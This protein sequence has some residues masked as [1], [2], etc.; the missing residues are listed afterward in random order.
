MVNDPTNSYNFVNTAYEAGLLMNNTYTFQG[1]VGD[2]RYAHLTIGGWNEQDMSGDIE[3]YNST[4]FESLKSWKITITNMTLDKYNLLEAPA[5]D[6]P[7]QE[8]GEDA[9]DVDTEFMSYGHFNSG[10][11]FIGVDPYVADLVKDDLKYFRPDVECTYNAEK[12]PWA[13][14]Y[15]QDICDPDIFNG[16]NL[17]FSFGSNATYVLPT[18]QLMINYTM[19]SV[20]YCGVAVQKITR[21]PWDSTTE[22]H[23]YFGDIFFKSFVG[24]FDISSGRLGMAKS[25]L[26]PDTVELQCA[27][28]CVEPEPEPT[29]TPTPTPPEPTPEPLP[30][31]GDDSSD[32][33][34]MWLWIVIA[35]G[36]LLLIF[37]AIAYYYC[38]KSQKQDGV[39][40]ILYADGH[41]GGDLIE[42]DLMAQKGSQSQFSDHADIMRETD[43]GDSQAF[44]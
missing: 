4:A 35:L 40:A 29:P 24:V 14:C 6:P 16:V 25:I 36:I 21:M 39:N 10:Y 1:L 31:P 17:T 22:R 38:R 7:A 32:D 2:S 30:Q 11:P 20:Q 34:L 43:A 26:S 8:Y 13:I 28:G 18:S 42:K 12:N 41:A 27:G 23:F 37:V 44:I 3:W 9:V 15:W 5:V 19:N 33:T